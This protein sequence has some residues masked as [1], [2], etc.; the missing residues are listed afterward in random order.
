MKNR[1]LLMIPGPIEFEP[2]VLSALGAPTTGHLATNFIEAFG[3]ALE[4]MRQVFLCSEGQPF[5]LAGTGTLAMDSAGANLVEPGDRALVINTGYFSDRFGAILERYGA[6]VTHMHASPG[7]RPSLDQVEEALKNKNFKLVT[8]THVDT[9][10]GVLADVPGITRLARRHGVLCVV[11]GVCS[12]AG[13]ELRMTDWGVDLALTASQKAVGVPPGLALLMIGPRALEAFQRRKNPVLNYYAD[14]TNWLPIM[15]AYE[16]RK[17]SYFATPAVNLIFAL[18]VSL[19]LILSEGMEERFA[20][21][22]RLSKACKAGIQALGLNQVPLHPDYAANTMTA[23]R[24]PTG[25][26]SAEFLGKVAKA[27]VTLAGG[28]HPAIRTEYFRIG[29][30]GSVNQGDILAT[31]GAIETALAASGYAFTPGA[32][33]AATSA[34]K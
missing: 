29:H 12:V 17:P 18:N 15:Q 20:R 31:L 26:N 30:M 1:N 34:I 28:L 9:S 10:T 7:D 33:V 25:I 5:V 16:A 14:W 2:A 19:G 3:Q 8:I 11:D 23:P 24:F 4:H 21:H 13:E 27:G 6:Q 22:A 32:G